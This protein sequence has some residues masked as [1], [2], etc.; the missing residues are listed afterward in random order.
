MP[1]I[2]DGV[3]TLAATM[4]GAEFTAQTTTKNVGVEN[5]VLQVYG[6]RQSAHLIMAGKSGGLLTTAP[7][8][9]A[10]RSRFTT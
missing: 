4:P 7:P 6:V 3:L 1:K 2:M 10:T 5:S 8:A 9:K